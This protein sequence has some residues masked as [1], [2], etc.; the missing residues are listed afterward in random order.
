MEGFEGAADGFG[1]AEGEL[2]FPEILGGVGEAAGGAVVDAAFVEHFGEGRENLCGNSRS[3]FDESRIGGFTFCYDLGA[4]H[5]G[6]ASFLLPPAAIRPE[7]AAWKYGE[8]DREEIHNPA[9]K[10]TIRSV[11]VAAVFARTRSGEAE[12]L[13][14][15]DRGGHFEQSR[16]DRLGSGQM[17]NQRPIHGSFDHTE[18]DSIGHLRLGAGTKHFVGL[19]IHGRRRRFEPLREFL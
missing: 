13:G 14:G 12:D 16:R 7:V 19:E 17:P 8:D 11:K 5:A 10:L 4:S 1:V 18:D 3:G 6:G 15:F 2:E 9:G